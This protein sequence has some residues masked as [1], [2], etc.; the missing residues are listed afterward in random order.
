MCV[1]ERFRLVQTPSGQSHPTLSDRGRVGDCFGLSQRMSIIIPKPV[2]QL[3]RWRLPNFDFHS[4]EPCCDSCLP[5]PRIGHVREDAKVGH[6]YAL[7]DEGVAHAP[8]T[9]DNREKYAT[10]NTNS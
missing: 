3:F 7:A 9:R 4:A 1:H 5:D 2:L 10:L 8:I 6:G